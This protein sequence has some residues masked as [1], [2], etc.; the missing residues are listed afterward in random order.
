MRIETNPYEHDLDRVHKRFKL[1]DET[2]P[3][4]REAV[5]RFMRRFAVQP[6]ASK[7]LD[8]CA[9]RG[10]KCRCDIF[11]S[12]PPMY[13]HGVFFRFDHKPK[14][15]VCMVYEPRHWGKYELADFRDMTNQYL[16]PFMTETRPSEM[17]WPNNK[18]SLKEPLQISIWAGRQGITRAFNVHSVQYDPYDKY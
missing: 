12:F 1:Y 2:A 18:T 10:R 16:L 11:K 15:I 5:L 3:G 7:D 4:T 8:L 17:W 6:I 14:T 13:E 9:L